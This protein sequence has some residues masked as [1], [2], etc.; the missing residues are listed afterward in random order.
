MHD[1]QNIELRHKTNV[2]F[3]GQMELENKILRKKLFTNKNDQKRCSRQ[4]KQFYGDSL[5]MYVW[6]V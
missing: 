4:R 3:N 2:N 6:C 1:T 5:Y